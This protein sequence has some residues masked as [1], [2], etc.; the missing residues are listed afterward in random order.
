[1]LSASDKTN[2]IP[3]RV[4]LDMDGRMVPGC[5]TAEFMAEIRAVAATEM[6]LEVMH[7]DPGPA[8]P[9]MTLFPTLAGILKEADPEGV[10]VPLLMAGVTDG[11][12]F[13]RLGI[14]TYGFLPMPMPA[15]FNFVRTIHAADERIP[16]EAVGFGADA[17]FKALQRFS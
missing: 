9:D 6:D 17:I 8:A 2:V 10:P 14:Q 7:F 12:F 11:R 5:T 15:D 4:V 3:A 16:V 1:M 13:S